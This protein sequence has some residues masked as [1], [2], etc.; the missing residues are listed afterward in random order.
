MVVSFTLFLVV[1]RA[2][3]PRSWH[4]IRDARRWWMAGA[5][6]ATVAVSLCLA[7]V[8]AAGQ[9]VVGVSRPFIHTWRLSAAGNFLN[10]VT[11]SG[12]MA[13]LS[14]FVADARRRDTPSQATTAGYVLSMLSVQLGLTGLIAVA[15]SVAAH[16]GTLTRADIVGAGLFGIITSIFVLAVLA[17]GRSRAS[18]RRLYELP[19]RLRQR[20]LRRSSAPT[21]VASRDHRRADELYEAVLFARRSPRRLAP[22]FVWSV[23]FH[24][25]QVA[26]LWFV[27]RSLQ[28]PSG[29][30]LAI[31][32]Y[33][34]ATMF[35]TIGFLPGGL[36]FTEVSMAATLAGY[37]VSSPAAVAA[38]AMFRLCNLW[39]PVAGGAVALRRSPAR[40]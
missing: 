10:L 29:L 11:K 5:L 9:A 19:G 31:V 12:G 23:G 13:G 17:A 3:I 33:A 26:L 4:A 21:D 24:L 15:I 14:G 25:T 40:A 2:E 38:V 1:N 37:G 34:L 28:L 16:E 35:A 8:H 22:L 6:A 39:L 7:S 18:A 32:T 36:G 27:L 20:L 30:G